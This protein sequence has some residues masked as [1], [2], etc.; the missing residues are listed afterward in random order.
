MGTFSRI[1][2]LRQG[3]LAEINNIGF[4]FTGEEI[5][6][7][8]QKN[9]KIYKSQNSI[10]FSKTETVKFPKFQLR[11]AYFLLPHWLCI[12]GDSG[13]I[14][15]DLRERKIK[16]LADNFHYSTFRNSKICNFLYLG[17]RLDEE[18]RCYTKIYDAATLKVLD[19]IPSSLCKE[20]TTNGYWITR[21]NDN[22]YVIDP[23]TRETLKMW[24]SRNLSFIATSSGETLTSRATPDIISNIPYHRMIV[25]IYDS[26]FIYDSKNDKVISRFKKAIPVLG[27]TKESTYH[28]SKNKKSIIIGS[29]RLGTL[30][31]KES[32]ENTTRKENTSMTLPPLVVYGDEGMDTTYVIDIFT[33]KV[34]QKFRGIFRQL[35][36]CL[37]ISTRDKTFLLD[38]EDHTIRKEISGMFIKPSSESRYWLVKN[39]NRVSI[40]NVETKKKIVALNPSQSK[41]ICDNY[42]SIKFI[43][44]P[45]LDLLLIS[46]SDKSTPYQNG[47]I[48]FIFSTNGKFLSK[49]MSHQPFQK[50]RYPEKNI[51]YLLGT[52]GN[53]FFIFDLKKLRIVKR[54]HNPCNKKFVYWESPLSE[55]GYENWYCRCDSFFLIFNPVTLK[56]TRWKFHGKSYNQGNY[57]VVASDSFILYFNPQRSFKPT[58]IKVKLGKKYFYD[59]ISWTDIS[60]NFCVKGEN[61]LLY[62]SGNTGTIICRLPKDVYE[63]MKLP[64]KWSANNLA[65]TKD[66]ILFIFSEMNPN[67][68]TK[69]EISQGFQFSGDYLFIVKN[70]KLIIYDSY[71]APVREI[72]VRNGAMLKAIKYC[73]EQ[74][75][76]V[77]LENEF[78]ILDRNNFNVIYRGDL[79]EEEN[80]EIKSLYK[81]ETFI[82]ITGISD[83]TQI[84]KFGVSPENKLLPMKEK[85]FKNSQRS[86]FGHSL[87]I[88]RKT[89]YIIPRDYPIKKV[90]VH[91]EDFPIIK[92]SFLDAEIRIIYL[93]KTEMKEIKYSFLD[94]DITSNYLNE[95]NSIKDIKEDKNTPFF[96]K[97]KK[98]I[99]NFC[100]FLFFLFRL[101]NNW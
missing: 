23:T 50:I 8:F 20:D 35:P 66:K 63:L 28:L 6:Y 14:F 60:P 95:P 97:F 79:I 86:G 15:Y 4:I 10:H 31:R 61:S 45:S 11:F 71:L 59:N 93:D 39:N 30:L 51:N 53:K 44:Y 91:C 100:K 84:H 90:T 9:L 80:I 34:K 56:D 77:N 7:L 37:I 62:I 48:V 65:F 27:Y 58:K 92:S 83:S 74:K 87:K 89:I 88:P 16:K 78:L 73:G 101:P 12:T 49:L 68:P 40:F 55:S 3:V 99:I 41:K 42:K 52:K 72:S 82:V 67:S 26:L 21:D 98:L 19:E 13:A 22:Y 25:I 94:G 38:P 96:Y 1:S 46:V 2:S 36:K 17:R 69:I 24:T 5:A 32:K 76:L 85:K 81:L 47:Q 54:I 57:I 64:W 29:M 18:K 33:G 70:E 43:D 75:V